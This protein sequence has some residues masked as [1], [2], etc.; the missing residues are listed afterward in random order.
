M[1]KDTRKTGF[2]ESRHNPFTSER[3]RDNK[4]AVRTIEGLGQNDQVIA[5]LRQ[6][7][8]LQADQN[9]MLGYL[10]QAEHQRSA[11]PLPNLR[12]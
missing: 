1:G 8:G 3:M 9:A 11:L 7:V 10:C 5:L 12:S 2:S 6:M 4:A